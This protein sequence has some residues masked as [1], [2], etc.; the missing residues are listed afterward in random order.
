L[1]ENSGD[2]DDP[3][4]PKNNIEKPHK[5]PITSKRK[6]HNNQQEVEEVIPDEDLFLKT[7]SWMQTSRI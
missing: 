3:H 7:W 6:R 2:G 1:I 4:H 5:L